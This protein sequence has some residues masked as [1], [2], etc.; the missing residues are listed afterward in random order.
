MR[1]HEPIEVTRVFR[2]LA[3]ADILSGEVVWFLG[4]D[5]SS[6]HGP[7]HRTASSVKKA[8]CEC[9]RIATA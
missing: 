9:A 4:A 1:N 7:D 5:H 6:L 2:I 8:F 3:Q